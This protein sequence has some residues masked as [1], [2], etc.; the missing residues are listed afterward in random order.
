VRAPEACHHEEKEKC[1]GDRD[2]GKLATVPADQ[3]ED[4]KADGQKPVQ[5]QVGRAF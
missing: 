3:G 4:G 2:E 5:K 1:G